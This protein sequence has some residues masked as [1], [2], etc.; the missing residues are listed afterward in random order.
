MESTTLLGGSR[1][2]FGGSS[3]T[4]LLGLKLILANLSFLANLLELFRH[5]LLS[6]R[7][8]C[9]MH[10][11]VRQ[12]AVRLSAAIPPT[13]VDTFDFFVSSSRTLV[14]RVDQN[15]GVELRQMVSSWTSAC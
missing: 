3:S 1:I 12:F 15:E 13:L 10:I 4:E 7:L 2:G 14:L 5:T 9:D 8:R 6:V 11:Q